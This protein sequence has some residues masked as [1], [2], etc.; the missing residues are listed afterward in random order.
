MNLDKYQRLAARTLNDDETQCMQLAI[1]GLGLAGEAGEVV[2]A[3]KKHVGHGH[4]LDT[5]K[6][7]KELGDVLWY[8]AAIA[9]RNGI[10]MT[11]VAEVNIKKLM[12]RY[13]DG[14]S[15]ERSVNRDESTS[16]RTEGS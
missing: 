3:I 11:N 4:N 6:L 1:Y 12:K 15:S 14:F 8:L 16:G 5:E 10:S 7:E 13:P 9:T 2:E